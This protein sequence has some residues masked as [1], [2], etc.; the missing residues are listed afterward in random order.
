MGDAPE[1][2]ALSAIDFGRWQCTREV[3]RACARPW[4]GIGASLAGKVVEQGTGGAYEGSLQ[5][6]LC[7]ELRFSPG[8]RWPAV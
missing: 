8:T 5:K 7:P 6:V 4:P 1:T 2:L 3:A